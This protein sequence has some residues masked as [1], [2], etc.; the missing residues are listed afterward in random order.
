[1]Y[2]S[3]CKYYKYYNTLYNAFYSSLYDSLC[4]LYDSL[5]DSLCNSYKNTYTYTHTYTCIYYQQR[6]K[7]GARASNAPIIFSVAVEKT[8][9]ITRSSILDLNSK[10]I[11]KS[12]SAA[13]SSSFMLQMFLKG[14]VDFTNVHIL[15]L[16]SHSCFH[17]LIL[18]SL[19]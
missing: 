18:R 9:P 17:L 14:F 19:F 3:L 8:I 4:S 11:E 1:M 16:S 5:Y 15:K 2:D 10:S 13:L 6:L 12:T 7:R